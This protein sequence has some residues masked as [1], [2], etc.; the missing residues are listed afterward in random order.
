MQSGGQRL[1]AAEQHTHLGPG[2]SHSHS[3]EHLGPVRPAKVGL[4]LQASDSILRFIVQHD[5]LGVGV[6]PS[7]GEVDVVLQELTPAILY[8]LRLDVL[9][10][11]LEPLKGTALHRAPKRVDPEKVDF[12]EPQRPSLLQLVPDGLE[13]RGKRGDPNPRTAKQCHLKVED[14]LASCPKWAVNKYLWQ[15]PRLLELAGA[16]AKVVSHTLRPV[17]NDA[18]VHTKVVLF[19]RRGECEG[20]PLKH[21]GRGHV[22]EDILAHLGMEPP[23]L[24]L[25][26]VDLRGVLHHFGDDYWETVAHQ[27]NHSLHDVH[28]Q[29]THKP[30]KGRWTSSRKGSCIVPITLWICLKSGLI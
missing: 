4:L 9:Q 10:E 20:V 12:L 25:Y 18:N 13:D 7:A 15:L 30:V 23:T 17:T 26:L 16:N 5:L 28:K 2:V 21:R 27:P 22:D 11:V 19:G 6:R 14:I 3:L 29:W 8:H 24:H 1:G